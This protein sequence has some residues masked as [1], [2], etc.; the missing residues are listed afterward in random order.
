MPTAKRPSR[1]TLSRQRIASKSHHNVYVIELDQAVWHGSAK[2][3]RANP[4]HDPGKPCLYVGMTGLSPEERFANH[5]AGIRS[6][7]LVHRFATR[8]RPDLFEGLNP[9][10]YREAVRMEKVLAKVL[11]GDG[12]GVWQN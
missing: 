5:R 1:R 4:D 6:S 10:S 11:R 12:Y 8:L 7:S 2:F 3:R 9:M